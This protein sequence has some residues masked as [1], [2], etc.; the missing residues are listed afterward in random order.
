MLLKN[1]FLASGLLSIEFNSYTDIKLFLI[2]NNTFYG[3]FIK[4]NSANL[5]T[6]FLVINNSTF[7]ETF[8][9]INKF[10]KIAIL[11]NLI[12]SENLFGKGFDTKNKIK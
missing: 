9:S 6:K 12:F 3:I 8:L 4:M 5:K 10:V 1:I 2:K 11:E 7:N